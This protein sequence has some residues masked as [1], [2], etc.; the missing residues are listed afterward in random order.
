MRYQHKTC[1]APR[2]GATPLWLSNPSRVGTALN[3]SDEVDD[4]VYT[5]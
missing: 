3:R 2:T 4:V 1:N 5:A